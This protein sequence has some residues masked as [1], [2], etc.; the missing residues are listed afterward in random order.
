MPLNEIE[1]EDS[2]QQ[3][4]FAED[5]LLE[6]SFV[7]PTD[8]NIAPHQLHPTGG[9]LLEDSCVESSSV[10]FTERGYSMSCDRSSCERSSSISR[11]H[12][13]S[14]M[15]QQTAGAA[16]AG[17]AHALS[18]REHSPPQYEDTLANRVRW[19]K[20]SPFVLHLEAK[21]L[22]DLARCGHAVYF[23]PG[24]APTCTSPR[25]T[26]RVTTLPAAALSLPSGRPDPVICPLP[27][28]AHPPPRH[29]ATR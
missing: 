5:S 24:S 25:R 4:P 12:R 11:R 16:A 13:V 22:E 27:L 23:Q 1:P 28:V 21:D 20:A 6:S 3:D 7:L 14:Q 26:L 29:A 10:E 9:D 15:A 8:V 17:L 2:V 19:L 18:H